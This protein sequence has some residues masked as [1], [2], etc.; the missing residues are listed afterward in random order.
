[1]SI[2]YSR[3]SKRVPGGA[4]RQSGVEGT[5]NDGPSAL[6]PPGAIADDGVASQL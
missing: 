1:M 4:Q 6:P 3:H 2:E 5:R